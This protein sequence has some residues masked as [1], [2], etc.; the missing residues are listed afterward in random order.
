MANLEFAGTQYTG[1][2]ISHGIHFKTVYRLGIILLER[3]GRLN[4]EDDVRKYLPWFP[5][6]KKVITVRHLLNHTRVT[7]INGNC[8]LLRV[9]AWMM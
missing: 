6:M 2:R 3:Q 7:G 9:H 5:D 4:L 8:S 1:N